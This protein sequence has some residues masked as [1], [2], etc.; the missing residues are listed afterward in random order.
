VIDRVAVTGAPAPGL[1][2]DAYHMQRMEGNLI[3][4]IRDHA[5]RIAHVQ[6][7][8][9]PWR[10]EPGTGE[11]AYQRVLPELSGA[12]YRGYVAL[13][14][15]PTTESDQSVRLALREA[16]R[17]PDDHDREAPA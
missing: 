4:T 16:T 6:I 12:G 15:K 7:A 17:S 14:Y 9:S 8:D 11:I 1:L 2:Y 3:A 10:S 5:E 13:E